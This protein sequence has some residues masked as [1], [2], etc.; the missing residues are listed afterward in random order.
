[1]K[2]LTY[3]IILQYFHAHAV[4]RA[5]NESRTLSCERMHAKRQL[6]YD[7]LCGKKQDLNPVLI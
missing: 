4:S 6:A 2:Y 7:I 5:V 1:L 3:N